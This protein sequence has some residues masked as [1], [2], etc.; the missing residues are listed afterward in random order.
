MGRWSGIRGGASL[1]SPPPG[2]ILSLPL[3]CPL[4]SLEGTWVAGGQDPLCAPHA[5]DCGVEPQA[6]VSTHPTSISTPREYNTVDQL[7]RVRL[8]ATP[9]TAAHQTSLSIAN[10]QSLL[11]L[12][13]I[14][15]VM[16]SNCLILYRPLL[17]PLQPFPA[18]GS[19][20]ISQFFPSGGQ[21]IGVSASASVLPTNIQD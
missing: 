1:A 18:S 7:S 10:S 13:S 16:P 17:L 21:S 19:F 12:V 15:S 6:S 3:S 4:P 8:F 9:W 5:P 2:V 11:K 20:P 14:E